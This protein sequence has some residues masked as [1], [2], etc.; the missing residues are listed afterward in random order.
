MPRPFEPS[1]LYV[2]AVA[3]DQSRRPLG[4]RPHRARPLVWG[5]GVQEGA[6]ARYRYLSEESMPTTPNFV[7]HMLG[8][9]DRIMTTLDDDEDHFQAPFAECVFG[10]FRCGAAWGSM[11]QH[12]SSL[13]FE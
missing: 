9:L 3:L 7:T 6:V 2:A 13:G 12:G 8:L 11:G 10:S 5:R 4:K 1:S